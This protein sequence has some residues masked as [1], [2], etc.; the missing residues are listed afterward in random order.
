MNITSKQACIL[1]EKYLCLLID[2]KSEYI[3]VPLS[4]QPDEQYMGIHLTKVGQTKP[5]MSIHYDTQDAF[6]TF[7]NSTIVI[8]YTDKSPVHINK[9]PVHIIVQKDVTEKDINRLFDLSC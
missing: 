8:N 1:L 4:V 5:I 7:V 6:F 3:L 9:T 2:T